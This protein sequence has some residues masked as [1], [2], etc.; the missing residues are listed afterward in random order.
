MGPKRGKMEISI[1]HPALIF[2]KVLIKD[3]VFFI[4]SFLKKYID[5]Q[6]EFIEKNIFFKI[7]FF[8]K[9]GRFGKHHVRTFFWGGFVL[10]KHLKNKKNEKII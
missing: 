9:Y 2:T 6:K 3:S 7:L 5:G 1:F 4:S 10:K 8:L